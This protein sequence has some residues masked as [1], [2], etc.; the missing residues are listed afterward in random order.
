MNRIYFAFASA[1]LAVLVCTS[2]APAFLSTSSADVPSPTV[3]DFS[4]FGSQI[5]IGAGVQVGGLVGENVFLT[6]V[7]HAIVGPMS[8]GVGGNGS[9]TRS[10]ALSDD[11]SL[12]SLTFKFNS[13]PVGRVGGF[14]NYCPDCSASGALIEALD[15]VGNV[16]EGYNLKIAAPISTGSSSLNAGAFRGIIRGSSDIYALRLSHAFSVVDDLAFT[17]VPE[18]S[19]LILALLGGGSYLALA[20]KRMWTSRPIASGA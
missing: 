10:G 1:L 13:G 18:P 8:H 17:R 7:G 19:A 3:I 20:R 14:M 4:Q 6:A 15:N 11:L 9:W 12:G 2:D 5:D 16:L